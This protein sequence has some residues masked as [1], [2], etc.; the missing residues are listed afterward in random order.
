MTN[1]IV[2]RQEG[3]DLQ[4]TSSEVETLLKESFRSLK[5]SGKR[6]AGRPPTVSWT[7]VCLSIVLCFWEGWTVQLDLWRL[8]TGGIVDLFASVSI[9]DQ[10]VYNRLAGA[11]TP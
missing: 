8:M 10:A 3:K 2:E 1:S 4:P 11:A 5:T 7:Q 6:K 9:C